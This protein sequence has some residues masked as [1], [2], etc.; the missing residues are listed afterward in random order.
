MEIG[1]TTQLG[2]VKQWIL[3]DPI[4]SGAQG[5]IWSAHNIDNLP[6]ISKNTVAVLKGQPAQYAIKLLHEYEEEALSRF[7]KEIHALQQLSKDRPNIPVLYDSY[8]PS[9]LDRATIENDPPF[10]VT[11]NIQGENLEGHIK[12]KTYSLIDKLSIMLEI[13]KAIQSSHAKGIIHRDL[14]PGNIL[15]GKSLHD[16]YSHLEPSYYVIDFGLCFLEGTE[17]RITQTN[18]QVGAR[19]FMAPEL[20]EGRTDITT[21]CD[22]YS[23]GKLLFY[24]VT[25]GRKLARELHREARYD[26]PKWDKKHSNCSQLEYIWNLLDRT[27]VQHP[28]DREKKVENFIF[29][30]EEIIELLDE[31]FYPAKPN[32]K[33]IVCGEGKYVLVAKKDIGTIWRQGT[34]TNLNP[35]LDKNF[36]YICDKCGNV[37]HFFDPSTTKR[38]IKTENHSN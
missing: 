31:H 8:F 9:K 24:L 38:W 4:G 21:A 34:D 22:L 6:D 25:N 20:E 19:Y 3:V 13:C 17:K 26:I 30:L 29:S 5:R 36:V 28:E 35:D 7:Q 27:L 12:N 1:I 11:E 2:K 33:C 10:Y 37:Q 16:D 23:L 32:R 18:E 15:F 14:H